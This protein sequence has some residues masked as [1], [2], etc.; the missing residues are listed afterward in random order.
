MTKHHLPKNIKRQNLPKNI[1]RQNL[2]KNIK[3]QN[4][5]LSF[6]KW[7]HIR[8]NFQKIVFEYLKHSKNKIWKKNVKYI[9]I[10]Q[11]QYQHILLMSMYTPDINW[12][13]TKKNCYFLLFTE[14]KNAIN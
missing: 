2:P 8:F 3:T 13:L 1:K 14:K 4:K 7:L 5:I 11:F 6:G 12:P 9:Y 10:I